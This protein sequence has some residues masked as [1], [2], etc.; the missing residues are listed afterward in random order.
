MR[1]ELMIVFYF[2]SIVATG[3]AL[4][5]VVVGESKRL[6]CETVAMAMILGSGAMSLIFFWLALLGIKPSVVV[7]A[8]TCFASCAVIAVLRARKASATTFMPGKWQG[9]EL[10]CL[11]AAAVLL[12]AAF[13][14]VA[15]HSLF[16]PL[17][18]VDSYGLWGLKAKALYHEGLVP[19]GGLFH[20]F[21][22]SYSHLNYPLLVP[23]LVCGIYASAG[24]VN[25]MVGK[26]IF[27]FLYVSCTLFIYSSLRWRLDRGKSLL[28][29]VL[30]MTL[31]V[32]LRWAGAGM[33]DFPLAVFFSASAFYL[34]KFLEERRRED[35]ILSAMATVFCAFVKHEGIAS[36][37]ICLAVI[38]FC[39]PLFPFSKSR[40]KES[41]IYCCLVGILMLPWFWWYS[42]VPH[43][44]E[45]YPLRVMYFFS[46]DNL[47][48][49][50]EILMLFLD[51]FTNIARW[52]LLWLLLPF[53]A[54]IGWRRFSRRFVVALWLL[55]A[56]RMAAY[57]FVFIISPW[58]PEFLAQMALERIL[59]HAAPA[60][61]FIIAF[62]MPLLKEE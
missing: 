49:T 6:L 50:R 55:L 3:Y 9:K 48:R 56:G 23:F 14:I 1:A 33:S 59:L 31:P 42:G 46:M 4:W 13:C 60:A 40:L 39:H 22:L 37:A 27:P 30:F 41:A 62:H 51:S 52:G 11:F 10:V 32:T 36:A 16:L 38:V 15:A 28:L 21:S 5:S 54:L 35:M 24:E 25:E 20:E 34:C 19:G 45:N 2:F 29:V 57:L 44:H 17:Y 8:S 7:I 61:L 26:V 58:S 47:L 53:V 12:S 18:D 43:T